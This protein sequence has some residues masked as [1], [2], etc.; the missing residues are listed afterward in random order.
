MKSNKLTFAAVLKEIP[1]G[2][3]ETIKELNLKNKN[4]EDIEDLKALKT[5]EKIHLSN[6]ALTKCKVRIFSRHF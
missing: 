1:E 4:I 5:L 3:S 6:N 2:K